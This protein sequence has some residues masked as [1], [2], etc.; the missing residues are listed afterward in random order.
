MHRG[1]GNAAHVVW[2]DDAGGEAGV[3]VGMPLAAARARAPRLSSVLEKPAAIEAEKR[4]VVERLLVSSPRISAVGAMRFWVEP[5]PGRGSLGAWCAVVQRALAHLRP[6]SVGVGPSAAVAWAA[7]RLAPDA[8][9]LVSPAEA[10]AFLDASPLEA[11]DLDGVALDLLA[12]LGIRTVGQLRAL[13]AGS[14]GRRLGPE[15]A[16][17]R[18]R[19]DGD[20]SRRPFPAKAAPR[21]EASV[22]FDDDLEDLEP[23]LFVL[24]RA[25]ERLG[26]SLERVGLGATELTLTVHLRRGRSQV[27]TIRV[28][29][30]THAAD[31]LRE[32]TRTHLEERR[33][34]A[35]ARGFRVQ[36]TATA[37]APSEPRRLFGRGALAAG[38]EGQG[39]PA[40][41][42]VALDRLRKR[43]GEASVKRPAAHE[44]G[45]AL[46]RAT[47]RLDAPE[48]EA[49]TDVSAPYLPWR[50]LPKPSPVVHGAAIV[51]GRRRRVVRLGRVERVTPPW[52]H[53]GTKHVELFA[54]AELEGPVLA[55]LEA[56]V[57]ADAEDD[58]WLVVAWVD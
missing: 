20:D 25:L 35:P 45:P 39:A 48:S 7:A 36:A 22:A 58:E 50:R 41:R 15:V 47:F 52:W 46:R 5:V 33:F 19:A 26:R 13:S 40:A 23:F 42:E 32:L 2:L 34:N 37:E 18:R 29:S 11:L 28:S 8:I 4:R 16:L 1:R 27:F 12:A 49:V 17:A 51:G 10:R 43:F 30:P 14:L 56:H 44:V 9:R 53:T 57:S 55:L 24:G 31:T 3:R 6:V 54:W 38:A 21:F